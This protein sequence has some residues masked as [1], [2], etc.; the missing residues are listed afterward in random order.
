MRLLP[1]DGGTGGGIGGSAHPSCIFNYV[2]VASVRVV[3]RVGALRYYPPA[4]AHEVFDIMFSRDGEYPA[5]VMS[6]A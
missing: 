2:T 3:S 5:S 6:A 4:S 1:F